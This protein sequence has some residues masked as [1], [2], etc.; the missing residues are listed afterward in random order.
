MWG[1]IQRHWWISYLKPIKT[2]PMKF[3]NRTD[4]ITEEALFLD[5]FPKWKE[6]FAFFEGQANLEILKKFVGAMQEYHK[7]GT[8]FGCP[9]ASAIFKSDLDLIQLY[10]ETPLDFNDPL[11]MDDP[12]LHFASRHGK[13][14]VIKLFFDKK[15]IDLN[16][17]AHSDTAF[18]I[19]CENGHHRIVEFF[20]DNALEK[21]I[22]LSAK[23]DVGR[24][25]MH[26]ACMCRWAKYPEDQGNQQKK[27]FQVLF[28]HPVAQNFMNVNA[29]DD[30]GVTPF[31][32][33]CNTGLLEVVE[34]FLDNALERN[35]YIDTMNNFGTTP[36]DDA[37]RND[38]L[39][40]FCLIQI[41]LGF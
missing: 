12:P 4:Q 3:Q 11:G 17:R 36:M 14:E 5:K 15:G 13:L 31:H 16:A 22:D 28:D 27:V 34:L 9:L 39:E 37:E 40:I 32:M 30:Q 41:Q 2:T 24:N 10:M 1:T 19:A 29:V 7:L 26:H 35:I 33:A 23:S 20:L 25:A 21:E 38:N 6:V 8:V 18:H